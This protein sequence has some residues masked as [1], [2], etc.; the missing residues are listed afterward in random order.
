MFNNS[1]KPCRIGKMEL[2]NRF[3]MPPMG[4]CHA[5]SDGSANDNFIAYYTERAKGGFSLLIMEITG[6]DPLAKA[7]AEQIMISDDK[8]IP[9]LKRLTDS[10]HSYGAKIVAQLH[11]A[12]RQTT[13]ALLNGEQ[14]VAPSAIPCPLLQSDPRELTTAEVYEL[15]DKFIAAAVRAQK[16]GFDGVEVHGAHGYLITQFLSGFSNKRTDEFGGTFSKRCKFALDIIRGI[17]EKCGRAFPILFRISADERVKGGLTPY[18]SVSI[19]KLAEQAGA[20]AIN[21]STANYASLPYII[22]PSAVSPGFNL[23]DTL[24]IKKAVTIPVI[25]VGRI[26]DPYMVESIIAD[27]IADLVALGRS[28]LSDPHF[29]NKVKDGKIDEI[30]PCVGCMTR[31]QNIFNEKDRAF[32]CMVNP[33]AGFEDTR[34]ITE[35]EKK[36]KIVVVGAGPAGLYCAWVL[37]AR[38]HNVTVLEKAGKAGGQFIAASVPPGKQALLSSISYY[39][40]MCKKYNV[41]IRYNT[42]AT[43]KLIESL[44]ADEVVLATGALPL[45]CNIPAKDTVVA[46]AVD[47]LTGKVAPGQNMLIVGGGMVG[48][49]TAEYLISLNRRVTIVEMEDEVARDMPA[50]V[51]YFAMKTL[52]ENNVKI[53]TRT[54]VSEINRQ[55]AVCVNIS[56]I[57]DLTGYDMVIMAAGAVPYNPLEDVLRGK[58][59]SLHVIGDA[60]E[61]RSAVEAIEEAAVLALSL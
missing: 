40:E 21:V 53:I 42:E 37:A 24:I 27:G 33:F 17:K 25:A 20:D 35:A 12:G 50:A 39:L 5:S 48:I 6:I 54:K 46:Q 51:K 47:V 4:S 36:K 43:A 55:G 58:V 16:A 23:N 57:V 59:K 56:G 22:A 32:S 60:K 15:I 38:G 3:V 1:L 41:E 8:Y 10:V 19:A 9:G 44:S 7:I 18:Q 52:Q 49:E 45:D 30:N 29:P 2:R 34:K 61:A 11:H 26:V 14:P 28:S 31:C 13:R